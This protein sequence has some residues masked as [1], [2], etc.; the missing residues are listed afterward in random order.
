MND[1]HSRAIWYHR[2]IDIVEAL[3]SPSSVLALLAFGGFF[4]IATVV[5]DRLQNPPA[6]ELFA[7]LNL[8]LSLAAAAGGFWFGRRSKETNHEKEE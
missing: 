2:L 7:V 3:L 5:V 1:D 8:T 4:W 6:S